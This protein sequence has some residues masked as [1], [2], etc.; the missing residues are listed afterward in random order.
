M[1]NILIF[2]NYA[3][4]CIIFIVMLYL[5]YDIEFNSKEKEERL[6]NTCINSLFEHLRYIAHRILPF[7]RM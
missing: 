7:Y 4:D 3:T 2:F 1:V 5:F 6:L